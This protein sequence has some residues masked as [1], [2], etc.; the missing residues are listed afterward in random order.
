M[1]ILAY[2]SMQLEKREASANSWELILP[3]KTVLEL[4]RLLGDDEANELSQIGFYIFQ[5]DRINLVSK[6][7]DGEISDYER[8]YSG[9][10]QKYCFFAA[11]WTLQSMV[12]ATILT[13]EKIPWC[14]PYSYK[15]KL[16]DMA[17][18]AEQEEAKKKS[19]LL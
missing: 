18:N 7:I 13:N 1:D 17:A 15:R 5:F 2:A 11:H 19:K 14:S 16:E 6:L 12:R 10:S 3:R 4:N 9:H 8:V